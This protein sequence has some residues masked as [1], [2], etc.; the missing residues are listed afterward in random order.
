MKKI[1]LF[2][3]IIICLF[4]PPFIILWILSA[5]MG[6]GFKNISDP[7]T[8]TNNLVKCMVD[9]SNNPCSDTVSAYLETR[10]RVKV[11]IGN[12]LDQYEKNWPVIWEKVNS[13]SKVTSELK[14]KLRDHLMYSGKLYLANPD[15]IDNY[16]EI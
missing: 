8:N 2:A 13:S 10:E 1:P 14:I 11:T 9:M 7:L 5:L 16:E 4:F 15:I 12:T 6:G 3:K